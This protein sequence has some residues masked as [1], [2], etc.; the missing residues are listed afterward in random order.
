METAVTDAR[1]NAN[2][3]NK[4]CHGNTT[5]RLFNTPRKTEIDK[6]QYNQSIKRNF[7]FGTQMH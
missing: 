5:Y 7:L 2:H 3:T 1:R 6:N 4:S